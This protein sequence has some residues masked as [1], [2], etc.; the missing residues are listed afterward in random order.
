MT[1]LTSK[2]RNRNILPYIKRVFKLF[3]VLNFNV[4][5]NAPASVRDLK[6]FYL[7]YNMS[8]FLPKMWEITK[9]YEVQKKTTLK[10]CILNTVSDISNILFYI[11]KC[12]PLLVSYF[13]RDLKRIY[14]E[15]EKWL[16]NEVYFVYY[17]LCLKHIS[18]SVFESI[19]L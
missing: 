5:R 7:W 6:I 19:F 15:N 10:P 14:L 1:S 12:L 16:C 4:E 13:F 17:Y 3:F 2:D 8:V 11:G 9:F 18:F